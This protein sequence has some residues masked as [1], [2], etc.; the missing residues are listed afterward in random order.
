MKVDT[1][2]EGKGGHRM[3]EI[4]K[5]EMTLFRKKGSRDSQRGAEGAWRKGERE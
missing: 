2:G 3:Y 4:Q 5:Q 1:G